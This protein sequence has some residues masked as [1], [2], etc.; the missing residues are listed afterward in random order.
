MM[1]FS[2]T[3]L[4]I[5][6]VPENAALMIR[7]ALLALALRESLAK[8]GKILKM[9]VWCNLIM[10]EAS[11]RMDFPGISIRNEVEIKKRLCH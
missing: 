3:N 9:C 2:G 11:G 5:D 8:T 10:F 4:I 6:G 1:R 7:K